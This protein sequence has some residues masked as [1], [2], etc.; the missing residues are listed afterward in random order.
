MAPTYPAPPL[1]SSDRHENTNT[2]TRTHTHH[3][4][5]HTYSHT[6]NVGKYFGFDNISVKHLVTGTME[7]EYS[8]S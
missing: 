2:H 1:L 3:T 6:C 8:F 4:R 7:L 5:T